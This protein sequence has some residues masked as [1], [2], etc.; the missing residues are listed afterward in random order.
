VSGVT[1]FRTDVG[2]GAG[3][4]ARRRGLQRPRDPVLQAL[5]N[6]GI[7]DRLAER[8]LLAPMRLTR[9]PGDPG[10]AALE[11]DPPDFEVPSDRFSRAALHAA[12]RAWIEVALILDETNHGLA[13]ARF[14]SFALYGANQ[15]RLLDVGS[16]RPLR[17]LSDEKPFPSFGEFCAHL[18]APLLVLYRQPRLARAARRAIAD[19]AAPDSS[20]A[21]DE[22]PFELRSVS[23]EH[24]VSAISRAIY[25][26]HARTEKDALLRLRALLEDLDRRLPEA[27]AL[28]TS[29]FG[30]ELQQRIGAVDGARVLC[31]GA[32]AYLAHR[33][34]LHERRCLVVEEHQDE[35]DALDRAL[36]APRAGERVCAYYGPWLQR[37]LGATRLATDR[38]IAH[39]PFARLRQDRSLQPQ[40]IA[41]ALAALA[42]RELFLCVGDDLLPRALPALR[43][44]FARVEVLPPVLALATPEPAHQL[45]CEVAA[46]Y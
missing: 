7:V 14:E 11:I 4:S 37:E 30:P 9:S 38:V 46:P 26:N 42:R 35:L 12:A 18:A 32:D 45:H 44:R 15:P 43:E 24:S 19:R 20:F 25:V 23:A 22:A 10:D 40:D 34:A 5:F 21:H 36:R 8:G 28:A 17:E 33:G 3:E 41:S 13:D 1:P 6:R 2:G 39:D 29:R 31:I 27:G 16:I